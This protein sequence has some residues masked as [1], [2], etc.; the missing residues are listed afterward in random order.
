MATGIDWERPSI[1]FRMPCSLALLMYCSFPGHPGQL[2][3][4]NVVF[5]LGVCIEPAFPVS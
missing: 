3:K 5:G 1:H 2:H 4:K